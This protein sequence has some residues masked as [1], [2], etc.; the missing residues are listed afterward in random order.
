M[1]SV[2]SYLS[3]AA[4]FYK[5]NKARGYSVMSPQITMSC[6]T[7]EYMH[8]QVMCREADFCYWQSQETLK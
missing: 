6:L 2:V 3:I 5:Y 4:V 8:I 7:L 1:L